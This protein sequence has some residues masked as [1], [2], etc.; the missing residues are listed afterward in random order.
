MNEEYKRGNATPNGD[1][2]V[3]RFCSTFPSNA[4]VTC[5]GESSTPSSDS[6]SENDSAQVIV[7]NEG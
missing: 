4:T 7:I 3:D 1:L 6:I 5:F 2:R